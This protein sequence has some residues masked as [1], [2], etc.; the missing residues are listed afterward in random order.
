MSR[1]PGRPG[2][3][4]R[5]LLTE[6]PCAALVHDRPWSPRYGDDAGFGYGHD[7][8]LTAAIVLVQVGAEPWA[9]IS[10]LV[11]GLA[12]SGPSAVP[13]AHLADPLE[14]RRFA[15]AFGAVTLVF[16]LA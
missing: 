8:G 16:G 14:P 9:L 4:C 10:A 12:M 7:V 5:P 6:R 13:A 3:R 2:R 11:F 15:A 1:I